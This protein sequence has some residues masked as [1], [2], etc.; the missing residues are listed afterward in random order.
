MKF[1]YQSGSRPLDGYTI[2]RGI[3]RGGF[4]EVYYA[5][6]DG[7]KEVALKLV[8]RNLEIELRGITHCLNLNHPN[9]L[10]LHDIRED[11]NG[12]TWVVME[13]ISGDCLDAALEQQPSGLTTEQTLAWIHGIGA[14]VSYLHD[15]G[16]VH[17]DLKPANIFC[18]ESIVKIGDYGLSKF[19]SVSRRSGQ[20][21]SVGTVHYMAPEVAN[22]RYGKEIDIYALGI[23]L[24]EMLTGRV[25]FEGESVGEVLMK[26]LTAEPD[27]SELNE[28][29][30]SAVAAALHKDPEQRASTVRE[31]LAELPPPPSGAVVFNTSRSPAAV[32]AAL[33]DPP[34]HK[35]VGEDQAMPQPSPKPADDEEP[36]L[37]AVRESFSTVWNAIDRLGNPLKVI[38][39]IAVFVLLIESTPLWI[40]WV[41][42]AGFVY[43]GYRLARAIFL[44][45]SATATVAS[46]GEAVATDT[47]NA[48][49]A[50][51]TPVA[52]ANPPSMKESATKPYRQPRRKRRI[53]RRHPVVP[54]MP[55]KP[56]RERLGDLLGSMVFAALIVS[57][58]SVLATVMLDGVGGDH[59]AVAR[60]AWTAL[61]GTVG[62]WAILIPA[63]FWEGRKGDPTMRRFVLLLSGL[64]VGLFAAAMLSGLMLDLPHDGDWSIARDIEIFEP[65]GALSDAAGQPT[66]FGAMA[67]FGVLLLAVR[68][69][70]MADPLRRTRLSI[71]SVFVCGLFAYMIPAVGV[72][73]PQ[74]WGVI[75]AV[76]V[77]VA[78]QMSS[79][80]ASSEDRPTQQQAA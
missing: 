1:T 78:V 23:I 40:P 59:F 46:A 22:G 6:S 54:A 4:G 33:V 67:Y 2:K 70:K 56:A 37:K 49:T 44:G 35:T 45:G 16:I 3:G 24:F 79:P 5:V 43:G 21:E 7:G 34:K 19:I 27:L 80:W 12:D 65:H 76:A 63:K 28:P 13:F 32:P 48:R 17:R 20:T 41:L 30:R 72:A 8:R 75:V 42:T 9:L 64:I 10:T 55:V 31:F 73:F 18:D 11:D 58:V 39:L 52:A 57:L 53:R 29:Y 15:R 62:T 36:I 50:Q 74:P 14:G 69:W 71:W 60:F 38:V 61:V 26:H 77:A 66:V 51:A 47:P 68:W 25:P